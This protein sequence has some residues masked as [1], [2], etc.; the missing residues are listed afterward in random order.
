MA[1]DE[2]IFPQEEGGGNAQYVMWGG[3]GCW[4][5]VEEHAVV[6]H[7]LGTKEKSCTQITFPFSLDPSLD[8]L[9]LPFHRWRWLRPLVRGVA[10]INGSVVMIDD[11]CRGGMGVG[12]RTHI[13]IGHLSQQSTTYRVSSAVWKRGECSFTCRVGMLVVK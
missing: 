11:E 2:Q 13:S 12:L 6:M 8:T 10:A 4:G 1:T 7:H 5:D 3:S 9:Q